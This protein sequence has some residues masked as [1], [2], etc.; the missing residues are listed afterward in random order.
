MFYKHY[1]DLM[2]SARVVLR[3]VL[4]HGILFS[5][6][7]NLIF[8]SNGK[9]SLSILSGFF[10]LQITVG[11]WWDNLW[12]IANLQVEQFY[13]WKKEIIENN[14]FKHTYIQVF[15][16]YQLPV[17]LTGWARLIRSHS[18]ARI[19]FELSGNLN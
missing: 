5:K 4:I 14:L 18:S 8:A 11:V 19:S 1:T 17:A 9:N 16:F 10:N 7:T 3:K 6:E 12:N 15:I 2:F 13:F